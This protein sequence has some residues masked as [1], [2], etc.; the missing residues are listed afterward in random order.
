MD[1]VE[2]P[3]QLGKAVVDR[4]SFGASPYVHWS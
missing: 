4:E 3:G 2:A 1:K